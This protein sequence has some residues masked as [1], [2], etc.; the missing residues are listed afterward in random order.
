MFAI[1]AQADETPLVVNVSTL[2]DEAVHFPQLLCQMDFVVE[3]FLATIT[4]DEQ[5]SRLRVPLSKL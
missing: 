4:H 2:D 3:P 1:I 5:V